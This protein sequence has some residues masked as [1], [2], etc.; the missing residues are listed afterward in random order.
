MTTPQPADYTHGLGEIIRSHRLYTGLSQRSMAD[1][2]G[3]DRRDYQR[4]EN[5]RD[6][7]PPGLLTKVE[8]MSDAFD[9]QVDAVIEAARKNGGAEI[10]IDT[11]PRW[12]WERNVA[13]RA[14][15]LCSVDPEAPRIC[16]TLSG[17]TPERSAS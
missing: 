12:E 6:A 5:E 11:A 10:L 9:Q 8:N 13:G 4:I 16:L 1:R 14:A 15:L 2:L 3:K 7:C 17:N